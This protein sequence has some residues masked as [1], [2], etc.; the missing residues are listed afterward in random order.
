MGND[1]N[2]S[3]LPIGGQLGQAKPKPYVL[4]CMKMQAALN[5]FGFGLGLKLGPYI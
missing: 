2:A 3:S 5:L 1:L 4:A